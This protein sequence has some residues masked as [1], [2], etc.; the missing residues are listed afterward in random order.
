MRQITVMSL[1]YL[2]T[3]N[4]VPSHDDSW[5]D[6][7]EPSGRSWGSYINFIGCS[8]L[9]F[10]LP[11]HT[12]YSMPKIRDSGSK[13]NIFEV[14]TIQ[15]RWGKKL[16]H[17][18]VKGLVLLPVPL[19]TS[20]PSKKWTWSPEVVEH[21]GNDGSTVDQIPKCSRT[22]RKVGINVHV[23]SIVIGILST[24]SEWLPQGIL[25]LMP[26]HFNRTALTWI[27]TIKSVMYKLPKIIWYTL[28]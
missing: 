2:H 17:V 28:V 11:A 18:L 7:N 27:F 20:S 19:P 24:D 3:S 1:G 12:T 26:P 4:P 5:Y 25:D 21:G 15:T 14:A 16:A 10:A 6:I 22:A 8:C 13:P 9:L 23:C